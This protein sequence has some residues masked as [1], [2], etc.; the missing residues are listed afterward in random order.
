MANTTGTENTNTIDNTNIDNVVELITQKVAERLAHMG[1]FGNQPA[2]GSSE[3]DCVTGDGNCGNCG[4]CAEQKPEAVQN[5]INSGADRIGARTGIDGARIDH[6]L[7]GMID[8]TLL[9]PDAAREQLLKV[10]EEAK[11]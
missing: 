7:A 5:I 3:A 6:S 2:A 11:K 8:H 4:H 1:Y 10:C 9:K